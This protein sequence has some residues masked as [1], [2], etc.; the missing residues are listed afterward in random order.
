MNKV[1]RSVTA[2]L[3]NIKTSL[4]KNPMVRGLENLLIGLLNIS[5]EFYIANDTLHQPHPSG[6]RH[7][8]RHI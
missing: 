7:R 8:M 4:V 5:R 3:S 1:Q 2:K 6:N